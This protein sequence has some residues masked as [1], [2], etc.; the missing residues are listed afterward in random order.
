MP[1][2]QGARIGPR[3]PLLPPPPPRWPKRRPGPSGSAASPTSVN[4]GNVTVGSSGGQTITL[5]NTGTG[6]VTVSQAN[7]AGTGFSVSGL[8]LPLTL[9]AGQ[10]TSFTANFSPT[11]TGSVTGSVSIVSNATGSP[12]T[13]ALAGSGVAPSHYAQLSWTGSTSTVVGYNVY[14][15][16]VSG[17]PYAKL[18][19]SL[20]MST[21]YT[22]NTVAAGKTYYYVVTAV[23]SNNAES[24]YS[25]QAQAVVPSP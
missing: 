24:S 10:G 3:N 9:A 25:N 19:S 23:D 17:G 21:T 5:N 2:R 1:P 13:V 7:V 18:N 14:R 12:T 11:A 22:D 8:S 16:T 4:F 20:V 6:S 15:G